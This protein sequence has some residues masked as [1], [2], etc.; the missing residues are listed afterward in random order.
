MIRRIWQRKWLRLSLLVILLL[1]DL[2]LLRFV[3][4]MSAM[5]YPKW[6]AFIAAITAR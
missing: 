2:L 3:G 6:V 4:N 5:T 1:V